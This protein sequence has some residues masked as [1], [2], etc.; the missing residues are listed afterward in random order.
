MQRGRDE[1]NFMEAIKCLMRQR[2][3]DDPKCC[4]EDI[5]LENSVLKA[6]RKEYQQ[7]N[8]K[9]S[10]RRKLLPSQSL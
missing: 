9:T 4:G 8:G 6:V 7:R 5:K 3:P 2:A 1:Q 10:C